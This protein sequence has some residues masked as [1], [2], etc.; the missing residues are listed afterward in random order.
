MLP[1][2]IMSPAL[3]TISYLRAQLVNFREELLPSLLTSARPY[4]LW[5]SP[6]SDPS[7]R[8]SQERPLP[9]LFNT[10]YLRLS[11]TSPTCKSSLCISRERPLPHILT[12]ACL[13]RLWLSPTGGLSSCICRKVSLSHLPTSARN[14][15]SCCLLRAT[16]VRASLKRGPCHV[17]LQEHAFGS[18]TPRLLM[19]PGGTTLVRGNQKRLSK[20]VRP[21]CLRPSSTGVPN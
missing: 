11:R 19:H 9:C 4:R 1:Y 3:L 10:A 2:I 7:P 21:L 16:L 17:F 6:A 12:L 5:L 18:S 20:L 15:A 14:A 13:Y 8:I